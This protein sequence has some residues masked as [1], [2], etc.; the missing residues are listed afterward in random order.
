L[1]VFGCAD[2]LKSLAWQAAQVPASAGEVYGTLSVFDV[3]QLVH[4]S[5]AQCSPG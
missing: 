5:E 3:W 4:S 1:S 2:G